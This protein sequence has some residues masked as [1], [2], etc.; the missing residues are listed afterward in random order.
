MTG[1]GAWRNARAAAAKL[2]ILT[3]KRTAV[4]QLSNLRRT[5]L[6]C[7]A[8]RRAL[9]RCLAVCLGGVGCA[10]ILLHP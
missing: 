3:R 5:L 6:W 4:M 2:D 7:A 8:L 10:G 9:R 1:N